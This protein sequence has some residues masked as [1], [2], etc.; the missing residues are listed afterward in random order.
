MLTI[1]WF[2][3]R[4]FRHAND[5]RHSGH[6]YNG[7]CISSNCYSDNH[8]YNIPLPKTPIQLAEAKFFSEQLKHDEGHYKALNRK[9][10]IPLLHYNESILNAMF[11]EYHYSSWNSFELSY[12]ISDITSISEYDNARAHLEQEIPTFVNDME[13]I[14]QLSTNLNQQIIKTKEKVEGK[15]KKAFIDLNIVE[16]HDRPHIMNTLEDYWFN[17]I[18]F[19]YKYNKKYYSEIINQ[20]ESIENKLKE[21][22]GIL[23]VGGLG[24][25]ELP[26]DKKKFIQILMNLTKDYE[27][28]DSILDVVRNREEIGD[29]INEVSRR[30]GKLVNDINNGRYYTKLDCCP[31]RKSYSHSI[32]K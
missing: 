5:E 26:L 9:I 31:S 3:C 17:Q 25:A 22:D 8:A 4:L 13:I 29:R 12:D 15:V 6:I 1:N 19:D 24:V 2:K 20:L 14:K 11:H 27:I 16:T 7:S 23:C 21:R 30:I 28:W 32:S 18:L 10:F